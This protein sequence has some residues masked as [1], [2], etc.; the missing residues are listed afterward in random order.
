M[1]FIWSYRRI[2]SYAE[3][4]SSERDEVTGLPKSLP[5]YL[6]KVI[7]LEKGVFKNRKMGVFKYSIDSG[8]ETLNIA[9]PI[10]QTCGNQEKTILD[11]GSSYL[12]EEFSK[13][14]GFSDL[15]RNTL[16][17]YSDSLMA[18]IFYYIEMSE[19]NR[20]ALRWYRG[21]YSNVLFPAAELLSER[22]S[23]LLTKLGDETVER[24]FFS[25]YLKIIL[26]QKTKTGVII[27]STGLPNSIHFPLTAIS[28][29]N[30]TLN[31]EV[32][33]IFVI[34]TKSGLPIF[35]DITLKI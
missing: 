28:N 2:R 15:F 35:S 30:G 12:L 10:I 20:D 7:D 34:D 17:K 13:S 21:S 26:P 16:P 18:L 25:R 11:F 32:R 9:D 29:Y 22:I 6:G 5:I 23:E 1:P 8:Y 4:R 3:V 33:L 19:P 31:E 14:I 27:D 24:N